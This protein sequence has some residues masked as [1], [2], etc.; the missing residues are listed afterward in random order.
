MASKTL[1]AFLIFKA[2]DQTLRV[3]TRRPSLFWDEIYFEVT[4]NVPQPWGRLAG[5]TT[6]D[7]PDAGPAVIEIA[8]EAVTL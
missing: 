5:A 7:L 4:L 8:P 3:V 6:I 2:R 1:K